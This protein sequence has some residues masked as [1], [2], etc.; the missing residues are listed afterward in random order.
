MLPTN[1]VLTAVK[2]SSA[3]RELNMTKPE[4]NITKSGGCQHVWTML[5]S[6]NTLILWNCWWCHSGPH[7]FIFECQKCKKTACQP[8]AAKQ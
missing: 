1:P 3:E 5:K 4:A 8:C 6:D 7:W 2:I